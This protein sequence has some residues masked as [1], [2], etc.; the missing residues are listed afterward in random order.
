MS[1]R[2]SRLLTFILALS[3][4]V[5]APSLAMGQLT[6]Y[7]DRAA[8]R[9]DNRNHGKILKGIED[10]EESNL[11]T[12]Q[13]MRFDDPL[14][15]TTTNE[16]YP[17][18]ILMENIRIQSR[19]AAGV[20]RGAMGMLAVSVG[21]GGATSDVVLANTFGDSLDH[22]FLDELKSGIG[23]DTLDFAGA[24]NVDVSVYDLAGNLLGAINSPADT[25]G[26]NFLGVWSEVPIG[27]INIFSP[28]GGREGADNV[29]MWVVPEPTSMIALLGGG[30][31]LLA[32]RRRR[33]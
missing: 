2:N 6:W 14:D 17:N 27:R 26:T 24:G 18:G 5:V 9:A 22:M 19:T 3:A 12:F 16:P 28:G 23:F 33:A 15:S 29:E 11:G 1:M 8:F 7:S 13:L 30:L 21:R 10:F 31:L 20:P 32:R 4:A 25:A